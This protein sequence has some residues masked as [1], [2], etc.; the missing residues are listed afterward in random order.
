M[1][2]LLLLDE[3]DDVEARRQWGSTKEAHRQ[4]GWWG[5]MPPASLSDR[6]GVHCRY[7]IH[8]GRRG[9]GWSRLH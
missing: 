1:A 7:W 3:E 9:I 8:A 6:F 2:W 5:M 4:R